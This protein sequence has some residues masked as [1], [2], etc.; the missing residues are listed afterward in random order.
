MR[1]LFIDQYSELG[2]AQQCLLDLLPAVLDAGWEAHVAIP[3]D[4]PL[5]E[6]IASLGVSLHS[7]PYTRLSAGHKSW[8]DILNFT[9]HLPR[10][11]AA[12]TDLVLRCDADL[13][14]VNGP[15]VLPAASLAAGGAVRKGI[16]RKSLPVL[17]HSHNRL[18][19]RAD[20]WVA[21]RAIRHCNAT[22]VGCCRFALEPLER[23]V[24]P[25]RAHLVYNGTA[26]PEPTDSRAARKTGLTIGVIGRISADKGQKEFLQ[27]AHRISAVL[28][29]CRFLVCGDALFGDQQ[30]IQYRD[31]LRT[32]A[33]GLPVEFLG[34]RRDVAS[35]MSRLDLLVVPSI[36]EPG[37]PR[38]ILEAY[39]SSVPVVAFPAGGI[40]E[41]LRDGETGFLVKPSTP[42]ALA[43]KILHAVSQEAML[44]AMAGAGH[45]LWKAQFTVERYRKEM[46]DIMAKTAAPHFASPRGGKSRRS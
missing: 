33:E 45:E 38:V 22:V 2:G 20:R 5:A 31:S 4:G 7:I 21:T 17:F 37:A 30:A 40:P 26:R 23:H 16:A 3:G 28:P 19:Q 36:W 43:E 1:V 29:D 8:R 32:L 35:V 14:Y 15:R 27:A 44:A 18:R 42:D 11:A 10:L 39:A 6:S 25:G 13:V 12:I 24:R 41:I 9:R 34:W 46:L